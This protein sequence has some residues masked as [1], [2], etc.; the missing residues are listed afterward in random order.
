MA[1]SES[2]ETTV[3]GEAKRE[4]SKRT[5]VFACPLVTVTP[6]A[7]R[8]FRRDQI[9]VIVLVC[10]LG[11]VVIIGAMRHVR[12]VVRAVRAVSAIARVLSLD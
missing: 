4:F 10:A 8:P 5:F 9:L 11:F 3:G 1:F 2:S 6:L 12:V 7:G